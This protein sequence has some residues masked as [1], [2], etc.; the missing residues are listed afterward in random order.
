MLGIS[1]LPER[2][3][4]ERRDHFEPLDDLA[5]LAKPSHMRVAGREKLIR[6]REIRIVR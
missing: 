4:E 5:R 2:W 6:Q 3:Y 1:E